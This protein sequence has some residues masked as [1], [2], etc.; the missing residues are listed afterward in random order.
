MSRTRLVTFRVA[1]KTTGY[2]DVVCR[3]M[4]PSGQQGPECIVN[5]FSGPDGGRTDAERY[6]ELLNAAVDAFHGGPWRCGE[7][8]PV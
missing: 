7:G 5:S 6:C 1:V 4:L 3:S 8:V 2:C